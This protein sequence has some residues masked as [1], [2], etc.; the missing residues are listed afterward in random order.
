MDRPVTL[1]VAWDE[2]HKAGTITLRVPEEDDR[3]AALVDA[4]GAGEPV[5]VNQ[6]S[7]LMGLV[8]RYRS[9][10]AQ[11][12]DLR[13]LSFH[14]RLV[15]WDRSSGSTCEGRGDLNDP[16]G[17]RLG[18]CFSCLVPQVGRLQV[19]REGD[20]WPAPITGDPRALRLLGA[21]WKS[22]PLD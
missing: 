19:C 22:Q 13:I 21:A 6:L 12:F 8:G 17:A 2:E 4:L 9:T 10:L 1:E 16:E 14:S 7:P 20:A 11:R 15:W 5:D 3:A 18:P